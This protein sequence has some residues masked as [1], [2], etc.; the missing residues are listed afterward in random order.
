M[1]SRFETLAISK[2]GGMPEECDTD[3]ET[4]AK[5]HGGHCSECVYVFSA[6]PDGLGVV[7]ADGIEES[8]FFGEETGWH[9]GVEHEC[10]EGEEVCE[11]HCSAEDGEGC[12][13]GGGVVVP[14]H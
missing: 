7:V 4:V 8:V 14:C 11:G 3:A 10:Y 5:V 12:V 1:F 6:L 13:G 2:D 9:A